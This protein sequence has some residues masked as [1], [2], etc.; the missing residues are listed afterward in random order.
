MGQ[1]KVVS[2]Y[3][4]VFDAAR[5]VIVQRSR[6]YKWLVIGVSLGGV[7]SVVVAIAAGS[8]LPLLAGFALPSAVTGF[9]TLDLRAV[10]CWRRSAL[11][12]WVE[13]GL[14]LDLLAR[15]LKQVPTL[16]AQTV[17]G[18]V[19]TLPAWPANEVPLPMR[20]ALARAQEELGR[21]AL[22]MLMARAI[23]MAAAAASLAA[24]L[25][26]RPI[27]LAAALPVPLLWYA[28]ILLV[29]WRV[30]RCRTRTLEL[31]RALSMGNGPDEAKAMPWIE[32][33]DRQGLPA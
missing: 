6:Q 20:P 32:G 7:A 16:P 2:A 3:T 21:L 22:Q 26:A 27:W 8:L 23:A 29:K 17:A 31:L 13:G 9:L 24:A 5:E 25:V 11:N 12:H 14:Q 4:A 18:M 28:W 1:A 10:Q 19:E 30:R 33:M 15:T